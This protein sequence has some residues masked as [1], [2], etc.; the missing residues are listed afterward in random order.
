MQYENVFIIMQGQQSSVSFS[1]YCV[2]VFLVCNSFLVLFSWTK[3]WFPTQKNIQ[4]KIMA[5]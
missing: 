3:V 1:V 2:V 4:A 5:T